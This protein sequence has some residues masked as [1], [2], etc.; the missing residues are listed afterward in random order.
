MAGITLDHLAVMVSD[1]EKSLHF[2]RDLLGFEVLSPEEHNGGPLDEMVDIQG[3]HMRE[4]RLVPPGGVNGYQRNHSTGQITLDL[5][6]W[7]TPKS[8]PQ[9]YPINH[10]PSAHI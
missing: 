4:Y 7:L 3:V 10:V 6:Q 1:L 5:I 9:R 2:Y 8:L